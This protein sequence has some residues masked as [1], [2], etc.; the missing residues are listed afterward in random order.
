MGVKF[1]SI[2]S[3]ECLITFIPILNILIFYILLC[4][5][6]GLNYS[7]SYPSDYITNNNTQ[8]CFLAEII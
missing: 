2:L 8:N 7:K 6:E 4:N 1:S 3:L 5:M